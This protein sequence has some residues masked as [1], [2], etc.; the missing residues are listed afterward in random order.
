[1]VFTP[2]TYFKTSLAMVVPEVL[3]INSSYVISNNTK[4]QPVS[5]RFVLRN[6]CI[7]IIQTF[8]W[9][10]I[11]WQNYISTASNALNI[12]Y[13]STILALS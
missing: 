9:M 2:L 4:R 11:Y 10:T 1:M 8:S 6:I 13:Y 12:T 3:Q 5:N 7:K